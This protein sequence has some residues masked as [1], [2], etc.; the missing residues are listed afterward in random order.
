M[1]GRVLVLPPHRMES[2]CV[3]RT[4]ELAGIETAT[5]PDRRVRARVMLGFPN[6]DDATDAESQ[7]T[8]RGL[9][10]LVL[11][12]EVDE[13]AVLRAA[14][15]GASGLLRADASTQSLIE[16]V[17]ALVAG[18]LRLP[19]LVVE[20]DDDL[21]QLTEREREIVV[22]LAAGA[23]NQEIAT[24]LGISYHTV[25]THVQHV[26]AKLGVSHRHAVAAWV[27]RSLAERRA[28]TRTG[29]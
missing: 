1:T 16:A 21:A 2:Q 7:R 6:R 4:L 5:K 18:E 20:E 28:L 8:G 10:L 27:H 14:E 29:S 3:R 17:Q 24:A 12:P 15:C 26:M 22:L 9:P 13:A 19:S 23:Q 25:R 11:V